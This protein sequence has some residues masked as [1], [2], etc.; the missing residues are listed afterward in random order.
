MHIGADSAR[1]HEAGDG[2]AAGAEYD[3][4]ARARRRRERQGGEGRAVG[5][6]TADYEGVLE[7]SGG[8]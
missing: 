7:E 8:G 1:D 6:G 3:G 5:E 2:G 4:A